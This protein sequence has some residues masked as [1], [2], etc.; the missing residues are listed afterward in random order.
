MRLAV[1]YLA[2]GYSRRFGE[3]KLLYPL[4]GRPLFL[5]GLEALEAFS[6]RCGA[7]IFT[8]TQYPQI[9]GYCQRQGLAYCCNGPDSNNGKASSIKAGLEAAGDLWDCYLFQVADQPGIEPDIL[10]AFWRGYQSCQKGI[11]CVC[12]RQGR[13]KNPVIFS[14]R[15]RDRL[16][17][18]E[19]DEGGS[20]ILKQFPEDVWNY[21]VDGDPFF[22][23]VDTKTDLP[24]E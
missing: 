15:Y 19:D 8:V 11:G 17:A 12:D 22:Y 18:L 2:A 1:I 20:R 3:N 21:R 10:E 4:W 24:C 7:G 6:D 5:W 9:V 23:E 13:S 14:R 16:L